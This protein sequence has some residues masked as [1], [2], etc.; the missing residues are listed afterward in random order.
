MFEET[1]RYVKTLGLP[2]GDLNDLPTSNARFPDGAAFRIEVPTVNSAEAV[3]ALLDTSDKIGITINRVT[4]TYGMFR[5]TRQE[6]KEYCRLCHDYG[7]ELLLSVG[8]RATY[9]T[10]ATVLSPQ[11]V[12]ISYRLRGME[13]LLRAVE[14]VKRGID[15]G[16]RGFLI[17]DEGMLWLVGQMRK[18]G[19][20]PSDIIFKTSAHLGHC[21]PASFKLLESLGADSINPVRDLQIP[22]HAALRAAVTAPLDIHT[23]N[24]PGSGGFIRVYEA[25]EI[26]RVAAPVHLKTGNSVVSAHGQITSARDGKLMADQASIVVEMVNKYYPQ[27]TQT[28]KNDPDL[29]IPVV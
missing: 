10:G 22:M 23:D 27:A 8:P 18:D 9:D 3:A 15:L 2:E 17:Y 5:H 7:T 21:N 1:R 25:P 28:Q 16:C 6:I 12:R 4:E 11:G 26:V 20:L 14:D 29:R 24:P 13:Q 19:E